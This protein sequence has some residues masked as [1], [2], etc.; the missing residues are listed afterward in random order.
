MEFKATKH[1]EEELRTIPGYEDYKVSRDG[2][3]YNYKYNKRLKMRTFPQMVDYEIINLSKDGKRTTF[4]VHQLVML[5][6][7]PK[8][9]FPPKDYV[10][11]HIDF[12][13]KNNHIDNLKWIRKIDVRKRTAKPVKAIGVDEGDVIYFRTL[14]DACKRFHT[15]QQ[16]IR[17]A[18]NSQSVFKGYSFFDIKKK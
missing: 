7:G 4:L 8:R 9:P 5:S 13:K 2:T 17:N 14:T 11:T 3:I 16:K 1:T 18:I 12:N 10:I 15:G 6:W